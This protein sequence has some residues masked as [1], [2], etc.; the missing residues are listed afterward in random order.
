[1]NPNIEFRDS[2]NGGPAF[3]SEST[4]QPGMTLRDYFAAHALTGLLATPQMK[5]VQAP[6]SVANVA[7]LIADA[8]LRERQRREP[9]E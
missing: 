6:D 3:P 8:M 1:M 5:L 9:Q 4:L 2:R 7:F